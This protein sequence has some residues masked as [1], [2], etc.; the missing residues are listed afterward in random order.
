MKNIAVIGFTNLKE[1][2][3]WARDHIVDCDYPKIGRN[4]VKDEE[5]DIVYWCITCI[6][7]IDGTHFDEIVDIDPVRESLRKHLYAPISQENERDVFSQKVAE[8][9]ADYVETTERP[10]K[11]SGHSDDDG[12]M[13]YFTH[14]YAIGERLFDK[15]L[16]FGKETKNGK[17]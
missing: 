7:D 9:I 15:G 10:C 16:R 14:N 4:W 13:L 12:E 8:I 17:D 3:D 11:V 6:S 1:F 5:K 2:R